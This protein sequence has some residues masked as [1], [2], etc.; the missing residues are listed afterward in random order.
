MT[1]EI[2]HLP[3]LAE[4]PTEVYE[5]ATRVIPPG[6]HV[7]GMAESIRD[8][9]PV[10]GDNWSKALPVVISKGSN[11]KEHKHSE[12]TGVFYVDLGDPPC[13]II[14]EG[15]RV[16]P[17]K[18]DLIIM[19]PNTLHSVEQSASNRDRISFAMLVEG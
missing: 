5:A 18:G 11:I 15:E 2:H 13:A 4:I 17:Q 7:D 1:Y 6:M 16:E 10:E 9:F 3:H 8:Y 12:W 19:E 14:I